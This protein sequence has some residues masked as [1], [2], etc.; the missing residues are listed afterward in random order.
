MGTLDNLGRVSSP[1]DRGPHGFNSDHPFSLEKKKITRVLYSPRGTR[2]SCKAGCLHSNRCRAVDSV[3]HFDNGQ[4]GLNPSFWCQN[5]RPNRA[6][7]QSC[8]AGCTA[9]FPNSSKSMDIS[10]KSPLSHQHIKKYS[11]L[12]S[13][14]KFPGCCFSTSPKFPNKF[15]TQ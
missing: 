1:I 12:L 14:A 8:S 10:V 15:S 9:E 5:R 2:R 6:P 3:I 11:Y 7:L 13:P 4:L